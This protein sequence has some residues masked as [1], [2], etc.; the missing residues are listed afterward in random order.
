MRTWQRRPPAEDKDVAEEVA[1]DK[2]IT[3]AAEEEE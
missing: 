2:G 3:E 1:K